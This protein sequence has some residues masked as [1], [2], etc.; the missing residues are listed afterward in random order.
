MALGSIVQL[1]VL[2]AIWGSSFLFMK[3]AS[4]VLGAPMVA[5]LRVGLAA[6]FLLLIALYLRKPFQLSENWRHYLI[7]GF[8]N[9]ALPFLLFCYAALNLTVSMLSILNATSPIW[10]AVCVAVWDRQW[11]PLRSAF[12]LVLGVIG[13]SVL[14][15]FDPIMMQPDNILPVLAAL[16][17]AVCYG[18][19]STYTR[20]VKSVDAFN[21]AHGSMWGAT[22]ALLLVVP[23]FPIQITSDL[24]VIAAV[25]ILGVLCSGVAY[26]LY[27]RLV[28]DVGAPSALTVT[29]LVPVFGVFWGYIFLDEMVGWHTLVGAL[30]VVGGT[31]LVTGFSLKRL[32]KGKVSDG[33]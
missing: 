24:D 3:I 13:V 19:T 29:F 20:H 32:F 16:L 15:G 7:V 25:V 10:G 12:G 6:V 18:L 27:F 17:A 33:E 23:F 22:L 30:T 9:S 21:N 14:L 1:V 31:V 8:F 28:N 2:A 26:L 11:M 5:E 4:P